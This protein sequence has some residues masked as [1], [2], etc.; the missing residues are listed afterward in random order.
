MTKDHGYVFE[1]DPHDPARQ[2]RPA[3]RSRRSAATPTRRVVD[4]PRRGHLYLTEDAAGPNGL[5]Y[6]WTPP[7]GFRHGRGKLRTLADDAGSLQAFKCFDS[8]GTFV[9][10][11]SRA[12][13]TGTV[14][15]VDWVDGAGPRRQDQSSAS[16]SPTARSPAAASSRAC[17]GATAAPTS[18]RSFARNEDGS[19]AQHDGQVW[20]YDPARDTIE[21]KLLFA[22]TPTRTRTATPTAP[23]TSPSPPTAG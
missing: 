14:Y 15:G 11:L 5:L 6:R 19:A 12:T 13:K 2:P 7:H 21:L 1:V 16:S 18:S 9:D 8:G 23:T 3:S 22:Y 4:R 20:F 10:D 17:G